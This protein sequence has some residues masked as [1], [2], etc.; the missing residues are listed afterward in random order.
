MDSKKNKSFHEFLNDVDTFRM[1]AP[2]KEV[3]WDEFDRLCFMQCTK[4]E[5]ATWFGMNPE[6]LERRVKEKF[7]VTF[8]LIFDQKRKGGHISLRRA[9]WRNALN[10]DSA[11]MQIWLDKKYL[12]GA[13]I[14]KP[15]ASQVVVEKIEVSI[16]D[17]PKE[18]I[19]EKEYL[20]ASK[21]DFDDTDK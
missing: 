2:R 3:I 8:S 14:D 13:E 5:I 11:S 4:S 19:A 7:N 9:Q 1:G 17:L 6:T 20:A 10:C 21:G 16:V 12:E 18:A 15:V